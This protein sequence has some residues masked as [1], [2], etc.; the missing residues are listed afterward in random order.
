MML[1]L[2]LIAAGLSTITLLDRSS[3]RQA[4]HTTALELAQGN[5]EDLTAMTYSPPL[6]PFLATTNTQKTNVVLALK[7]N[8]TN[9]LVAGTMTTVIAPIAQGHLVTVTVSTTNANQVLNAQL[10]T[11]INEKSGSQP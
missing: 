9:V 3:R 10:Q 6:A 4:L 11:V 7:N 2:M 5:I 8:S 1:V